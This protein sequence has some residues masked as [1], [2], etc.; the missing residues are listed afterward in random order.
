M[1]AIKQKNMKIKMRNK[2]NIIIKVKISKINNNYFN[3]INNKTYN[4][5][6]KKT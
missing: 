4:N 1:I 3:F 5:K 2:N 6:I